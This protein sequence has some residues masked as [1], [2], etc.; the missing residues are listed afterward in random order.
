MS[1]RNRE[2]KKVPP[3]ERAQSETRAR[4]A[5]PESRRVDGNVAPLE[6]E[7][8]RKTKKQSVVLY[9]AGFLSRRRAVVNTVNT[10]RVSNE[11]VSDDRAQRESVPAAAA[12]DTKRKNR[13]RRPHV[14]DAGERHVQT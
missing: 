10:L 5:V 8:L 12:A 9:R 7:N 3:R 13:V 6:N 11:S 1:G 4:G 14:V 2:G